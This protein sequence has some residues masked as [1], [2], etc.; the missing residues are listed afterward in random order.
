MLSLQIRKWTR[1]ILAFDPSILGT[2][3][4]AKWYSKES[5][6]IFKYGNSDF[7]QVCKP[8]VFHVDRTNYIPLLEQSG[9]VLTL[10]RPRLFGKTML[11]S[12]IDYYYNVLY[13]NR[14][15]ELFGH[16]RIGKSPTGGQNLYLVFRISLSNLN[17]ENVESFEQSLNDTINNAVKRFKIDYEKVF[18]SSIE[19]INVCES[20]GISSFTSLTDFVSKSEYRSKV[21]MI[22]VLIVLV[23][24][25]DR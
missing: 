17:T 13:K 10:L 6:L 19:S 2:R 14:F 20:N 25:V 24:F 15:N 12:M 21:F 7:A 22:S 3:K 4:N 1:K 9:E 8:G 18:G 16:L 11:V 23:V 5:K